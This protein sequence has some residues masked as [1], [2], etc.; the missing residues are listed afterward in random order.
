MDLKEL[1]PVLL[2]TVF[3]IISAAKKKKQP[4]S[5]SEEQADTAPSDSPW[6][7]LMRE[8][9]KGGGADTESAADS[10]PVQRTV[11]DADALPTEMLSYDDEAIEAFENRTVFS[12]DD[13]VGDNAPEPMSTA[14]QGNSGFFRKGVSGRFRSENGRAVFRNSQ[15]A[16]LNFFSMYSDADSA[17]PIRADY[18]DSYSLDV[19]S[20]AELRPGKLLESVFSDTPRWVNG[21]MKIRNALVAPFG[22][23]TGESRVFR[24]AIVEESERE[25]VLSNDDKHLI[26]TVSL[27]VLPRPDGVRRISI[28]TA[29]QYHNRLGRI[30]FALI[31]PFHRI[32]IRRM[33]RRIASSVG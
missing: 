20:D 21:L 23:K 32:I 19:S 31:R 25:A 22:L 12:Y 5:E 10:R 27:S 2:I 9:K 24:K 3:A 8:L 13:M 30:Y 11:P 18:S 1:L 15:T 29:V 16:F 14:D 33:L 28:S 26:F 17:E 6:D 7:D 4:V